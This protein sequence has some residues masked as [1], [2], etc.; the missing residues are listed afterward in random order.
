MSRIRRVPADAI[1][2]EP[3]ANGGGSTTVLASGPEPSQ[4]LWRLSLAQIDQD[5]TFSVLA[6]TRRQ[7]VPLDAPIHLQ[8]P[9]GSVTSLLRLQRTCFDGIDAP[10]AVL[11]DGPTRAFNLMLRGDRQGD[12][13]A[14]PLQGAMV[15]SA[16][17]GVRWFVHL[18]AGQAQVSADGDR[19]DIAQGE[20][21]WVEAQ[22]GFRVEGGGEVVLVRLGA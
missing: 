8:F 20:S 17:I 13:I 4:W 16:A 10:H 5:S 15:M 11:P 3:W 21:A 22:G 18:V 2:V 12:L 9:D 7:F 14:R 19:V 6:D 1:R